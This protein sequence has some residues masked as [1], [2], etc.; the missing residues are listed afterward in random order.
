MKIRKI[1]YIAGII[2]M[3]GI[4]N[5]FGQESAT[6]KG[7][8]RT[9]NNIEFPGVNL[10]FYNRVLDSNFF[11]ETD[12]K[13]EYMIKLREGVYS[14]RTEFEGFTDYKLDNIS[15]T[16]GEIKV[17]DITLNEKVYTTETINVEEYFRQKQNDLRTSLFNVPPINI[18]VLPGGIE[19]VLRSLK[20]LPGVTS[21]NDFTSQLVV[22]GSGPDQNLIIMDDVEI[23]NPYR[24][25][26]LV[27]MFNPETLSDINL[28]TGGFPS[29]YGDRLSA[30]LDVTNKEG[31]RDRPIS[32]LTNINIANANIIV[33]GKNPLKIPGSWIV[34]TRRTYYD[35]IVGPFAKSAGLITDDSSFPS[36]Q[37]LQ[38]KIAFGPFKKNKFII[39]G[40]FSRDGVDIISGDE[41]KNADSVNVNDVTH[42]NVLSLSWHYIPNQN[43]ISKTT[44]SYYN[45]SGDN[46]FEGDILDPLLDREAF[47]PGQRDSL[48]SIGAMLGFNFDSKYNFIKISLGNRSA[49]WYGKYYFEFGGGVDLIRN[50]LNYKLILDD[51]FK[52]F[53]RSFNN[54]SS[55][56]E[57]FTIEGKDNYRANT[58]FQ[59]RIPIGDRF[60]IQPSARFDY[61]SVISKP[62]ISPRINFGYAID[63]LTT[64]R[65]AF[66]F[67][68]QSPGYE[69]LVDGQTFYDLTSERAGNLNAEKA[70]HFVLG[71]DRW[72][73]NQWYMRL[74]GYYKKFDDLILQEKLTAYRYKWYLNDPT[75]TD[76]NYIKN[77]VNWTRS[78]EKLP[79]DS[80]T[81]TPIN[82]GIGNAY[83]V[84]IMLEKRYLGPNTKFYGWINYS[85]SKSTRQR[86][87]G[88]EY[89]F[90]FDQ[91]HTV[92]V[93][94][95][96]KLNSWLEAGARWTYATNFPYTPP[97]GIQPR[98]FN[99]TLVVNPFTNQVIFN[100]NY[101]DDANR[102]SERRPAYHRLDVRLTAYA[103]FWNAKWSFYLDVINVYNRKNVIGYNYVLKD[104]LTIERRTTGMI[105]I[106][107]TLGLTARF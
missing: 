50:D 53:L 23:F 75:N 77:P 44:L 81:P 48:K 41:R 70:L 104:D 11:A 78:S 45:N 100:L 88:F 33:Q 95:N 9:Q 72:L 5:A 57:D 30:V 98:N 64:V 62:Y 21:P 71:V 82:G 47:T 63:A 40:I 32:L 35:L 20:S 51:R 17:I 8:V 31:D 37:D 60:Y 105:P 16:G 101:G 2:F 25:Y 58:Y 69:K 79:V 28:I 24:L 68:Y 86:E 52:A 36:F 38:F 76:P 80:L 7:V 4:A 97:V 94:L 67:Y 43:F 1:G 83:G 89:P 91:T 99:D 34:S 42:N 73:N 15:L 39:N 22:R 84:E 26:G 92:N 18:K 3:L 90:R 54:A 65:S 6:V 87:G 102:F 56:L 55:L 10:I 85:Y 96:Y 12:Y 46:E 27:S 74:E 106:L 59:V 66:G 19:D 13:G 49:Y 107:P 61:Y 103:D 29:K 14:L 93:V